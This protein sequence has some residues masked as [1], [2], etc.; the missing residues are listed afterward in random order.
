M[1]RPREMQMPPMTKIAYDF[2]TGEPTS[3]YFDL[4]KDPNLRP[5]RGTWGQPARGK[6]IQLPYPRKLSYD[7]KT[8]ELTGAEIDLTEMSRAKKAVVRKTLAEI[9]RESEA[10]VADLPP[11]S[12]PERELEEIIRETQRIQTQLS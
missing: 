5:Q 8:G 12:R 3:M 7:M 6:G 11:E 10:A 9:L 4:S 1:S 2:K